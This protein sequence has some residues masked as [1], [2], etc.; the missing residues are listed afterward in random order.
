MFHAMFFQMGNIF[1]GQTFHSI[2]LRSPRPA[3][4]RF[5]AHDVKFVRRRN[6]QILFS[7]RENKIDGIFQNFREH[8]SA[9]RKIRSLSQKRNREGTIE[10]A[11]GSPVP[12]NRD[13]VSRLQLFP[14]EKSRFHADGIRIETI[15][16]QTGIQ[17]SKKRVET[18]RPRKIDDGKHPEIPRDLI[19]SVPRQSAHRFDVSQMRTQN[20]SPATGIQSFHEFPDVVIPKFQFGKGNFPGPAPNFF[21]HRKR[22]GKNVP[23]NV[24]A[25]HPPIPRV[26]NMFQIRPGTFPYRSGPQTKK[27]DDDGGKALHDLLRQMDCR[28]QHESELPR[29]TCRFPDLRPMFSH[30]FGSPKEASATGESFRKKGER[31]ISKFPHCR[32]ARENSKPRSAGKKRS[33]DKNPFRRVPKKA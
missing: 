20:E 31:A 8:K 18:F 14:H 28:P 21:H 5:R 33:R 30:V 15:F 17:F 1:A 24:Q 26:P 11:G 16:H 9:F 12:R 29:G 7:K 25:G 4:F 2:P 22:K 23:I 6:V 3:Q 27:E 10:R 13:N 19:L 32:G